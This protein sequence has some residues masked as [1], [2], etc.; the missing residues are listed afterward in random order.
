[1]R[2]WDVK[3]KCKVQLFWESHKNLRHPP[4]G[5]DIYLVPSQKSWTLI[6]HKKIWY[7]YSMSLNQ[8]NTFKLRLK[9]I[10]LCLI[11][12][13]VFPDTAT[14]IFW[15]NLVNLGECPHILH[16]RFGHRRLG[17][18]HVWYK[19]RS[20]RRRKPKTERKIHLR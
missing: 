13:W 7:I 20:H 14:S 1:M 4:Y 17:Y 9:S 12:P 2:I 16:F 5:F 3:F 11:W 6:V 8:I 19:M 15:Q 10:Y 18:L